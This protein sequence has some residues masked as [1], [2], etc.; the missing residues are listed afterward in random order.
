MKLV[1]HLPVDVQV[2][3]ESRHRVDVTAGPSVCGWSSANLKNSRPRADRVGRRHVRAQQVRNHV[4]V[5]DEILAGDLALPP[6]APV[7]EPEE[8]RIEVLVRGGLRIVALEERVAVRERRLPAHVAQLVGALQRPR[9]GL[10]GVAVALGRVFELERQLR[11]VGNRSGVGA[12]VEHVQAVATGPDCRR[13]PSTSCRS[14]RASSSRRRRGESRSW[15]RT[16]GCRS[17]PRRARPC[18]DRT[19]STV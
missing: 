15:R 6:R 11:E 18:R 9:I 19:A 17:R 14:R 10:E 13:R 8:Q 3:L 16:A 5:R 2:G 12:Q 1:V 7:V 4:A